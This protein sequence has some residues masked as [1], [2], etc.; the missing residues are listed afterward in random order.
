MEKNI[1][2]AKFILIANHN[3]ILTL[4]VGKKLRLLYS[5]AFLI[6]N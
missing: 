3:A 5:G 4:F 2:M 6:F 1:P